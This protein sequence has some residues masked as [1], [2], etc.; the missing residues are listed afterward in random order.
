VGSRQNCHLG[1][2][3]KTV[4]TREDEKK[5]RSQKRAA[6]ESPL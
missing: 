4:K 6:R 5:T 3:V 2:A 1:T